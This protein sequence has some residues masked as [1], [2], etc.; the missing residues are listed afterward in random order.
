MAGPRGRKPTKKS[1]AG[2]VADTPAK[3]PTRTEDEWRAYLDRLV[4]A[5]NRFLRRSGLEH[6]AAA[7]LLFR[8]LF[9]SDVEAA[10]SPNAKGHATEAYLRVRKRAGASLRM[11]G[12]SLSRHIRVGAMNQLRRD[13]AWLEMD[14]SKKIAL[15][16]LL[17]L[18]DERRAFNEGVRVAG[19]P[20][21]GV[22]L[23]RK[24][25]K[26]HAPKRPGSV[27]RPRAA[28]FTLAKGGKFTEAGLLLKSE[29]HRLAFRRRLDEAPPEQRR[30]LVKDLRETMD[31]LR[32][33]FAELDAPAK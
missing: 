20:N 27:G 24:W 28:G 5:T 23:L 18:A 14:W 12:P 16:P 11:D 15:L 30:E 22:R 26:A 21:M 17:A 10:L 25:V 9:G 3:G 2:L 1:K 32:A 13:G 6:D 29:K 19:R 8:E 33:L 7:D 31:G 4:D